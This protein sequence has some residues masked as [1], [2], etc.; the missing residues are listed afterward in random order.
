MDTTL[1]PQAVRTAARRG[2]IRTATQS[3]ASLLPT[4]IVT[5]AVAGDWLLAAAL[6]VTSALVTAALA[7]GASYLSI[8]SKG[9]PADYAR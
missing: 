5:V 1:V 9:V 3:L 6:S 7:G 4:S 8:L 2:F